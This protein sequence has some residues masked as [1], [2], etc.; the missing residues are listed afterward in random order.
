MNMPKLWKDDGT[1]AGSIDAGSTVS[2]SPST[3]GAGRTPKA[4][5][6][7]LGIRKHEP[8][9]VKVKL[10]TTWTGYVD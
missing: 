5:D 3:G 1:S 9:T 6:S 7:T 4:I 8:R 10:S 2:T